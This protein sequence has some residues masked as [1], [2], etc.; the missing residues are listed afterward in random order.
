MQENLKKEDLEYGM[1][2]FVDQDG[3]KYIFKYLKPSSSSSSRNVVASD[4]L[5][6]NGN[7]NKFNDEFE[8]TVGDYELRRATVEG[9]IWLEER[10]KENKKLKLG[11]ALA[12]FNERF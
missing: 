10:K 5:S 9:D 6:P 12:K 8:I 4:A 3:N 2:Y 1:T 7:Y 11:E